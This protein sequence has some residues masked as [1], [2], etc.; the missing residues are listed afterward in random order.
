[1]CSGEHDG[2]IL[3]CSWGKTEFT[4]SWRWP[5]V[6]LWLGFWCLEEDLG[7]VSPNSCMYL[8]IYVMLTDSV[9]D[10][11]CLVEALLVVE[12]SSAAVSDPRGDWEAVWGA[13]KELAVDLDWMC[14]LIKVLCKLGSSTAQHLPAMSIVTSCAHV[15]LL[16][17][18]WQWCTQER[19]WLK[20]VI[21]HGHKDGPSF[22]FVW[23]AFDHNLWD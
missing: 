20:T 2:I 17:T 4:R 12:G 18:T 10:I 9:A 3:E 13:P 15:A 14:G 19:R 1:M 16:W 7:I 8:L 11:G 23:P 5:K 21:N 6:G 22:T